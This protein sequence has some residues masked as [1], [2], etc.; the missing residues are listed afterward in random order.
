MTDE[1]QGV[2]LAGAAIYMV[3]LLLIGIVAA[4]KSVTAEGFFVA[5]RSM[6]LWLCSATVMATWIGGGT[7]LGAAGAAHDGGLL[8]VIADPFGAALGLFIVGLLVIRTVRRLRLVTVIEFI[9][10]RFG[11]VVA[12]LASV[13]VAESR[14]GWIRRVPYR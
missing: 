6:P 10:Q 13:A 4:R 7:M 9:H 5:G 1:Q 2:V 11:K 3:A 8:A 12:L 14:V